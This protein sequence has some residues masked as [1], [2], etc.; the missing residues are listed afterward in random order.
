MEQSEENNP[1]ED[2]LY[3]EIREFYFHECE[4]LNSRNY[5]EWLNLLDEDITYEVPI[6]KTREL[7]DPE[8]EF[9]DSYH[10]KDNYHTLTHK[11]NRLELDFAWSENPP[12]RT[13]HFITN[14]RIEPREGDV[15]ARSNALIFVNRGND[16]G[17]DLISGERRDRLTLDEE[18]RLKERRYLLDQAT[19]PVQTLSFII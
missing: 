14:V 7:G 1:V 16:P 19:L 15:T 3:R 17:H 4:L 10:V 2:S 18:I 12:T 6:R 8:K 11:I 13:R 9:S 5:E